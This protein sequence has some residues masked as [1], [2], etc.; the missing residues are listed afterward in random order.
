MSTRLPGLP[1][2]KMLG[3]FGSVLSACLLAVSLGFAQQKPAV[4][5]DFAG[6][7][8]G[9]YHV[10]L[11]L[12]AGPDGTLTGT[13]DS[14]DVGLLG[15]QCTDIHVNG[16]TLR[17]SVPMVNG[18]WS[19]SIDANG[20]MLSGVWN[21]GG[22]TPLNLAR[23]APASTAT[24]NPPPPQAGLAAAPAAVA[25]PEKSFD[26]G[27][28]RFN[29]NGV[30]YG[31]GFVGSVV[32]SELVTGQNQQVGTI[33]LIQSGPNYAPL[34]QSGSPY[35]KRAME[36]F[37]QHLGSA[38][39]NS[40]PPHV[41]SNANPSAPP[42]GGSATSVSAIHFDEATQ[43][44]TVP[45]PNGLTVTF[46]GQR[47]TDVRVAGF[48]S[49]NFIIRHQKAGLG[50]FAERS[51]GHSDAAGGSLSGGGEEF[52]IE[53][54]G[55]IYDSGMGTNMDMQV[56]SPVLTA[57]QLSQIAVDAVADVRQ[58]PGHEA[59]TPPGYK[60][61]KAISQYRLRSDGSR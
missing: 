59:F 12:I 2:T 7:L 24:S 36:I 47:Y 11:H 46:V 30:K 19:G 44:I 21:Q 58:I 15:M 25:V 54:G 27:G 23:I 5:G 4:A 42:V 28:F 20:A 3:V 40:P 55:L 61:L 43:N 35:A 37:Q 51:L 60:A 16:Q 41:S 49:L 48:H 45:R 18:T 10:K 14:P 52:L 53:G 13:V 32:V 1:L 8:L 31:S 9:Q 33:L 57:K 26:D 22:P 34:L 29:V 17:F 56:D 6:L 38:G 39:A 50:R